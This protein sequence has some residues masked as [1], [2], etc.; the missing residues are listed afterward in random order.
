[1][2]LAATGG[3]V[4]AAVTFLTVPE[5][6][7][8]SLRLLRRPVSM[9]STTTPAAAAAASATTVAGLE[10]ASTTPWGGGGGDGA[11][12]SGLDSSPAYSLVNREEGGGAGR[13]AGDGA[14]RPTFREYGSSRHVVNDGKIDGEVT[15]SRGVTGPR[16]G[17]G[18]GRGSAPSSGMGV[19]PSGG[20]EQNPR[21]PPDGLED[22][23]RSRPSSSS[24]PLSP[25]PHH[26]GPRRAAAA[27][28]D[29]PRQPRGKLSELSAVWLTSPSLL[30]VCVAGGVRDAG[31]FV[32]GYYLAS[33]FSPLLDGN[34]ALTRHGAEP[35]SFSFN[36]DFLGDQQ[37][38]NDAF[39]WCVDG[40]CNRLTG[41]P[42][43]D[44]G[45][46]ASCQGEPASRLEWFVSWVPLVGGSIGA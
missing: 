43:H 45:M 31:G 46:S 2:L 19:I 21:P 44:V 18:A 42:W 9:T 23:P 22:D 37:V 38:C 28:G 11:E 16:A 6:L 35:C 13:R 12:I 30:L 10:E 36:A 4:V 20:R 33:Y 1:Y 15:E 41:S 3:L 25:R 24:R 7:P 34:A 17:A 32:F 26:L 8:L 39:P 14:E 5:P 29:G 27:A 40:C